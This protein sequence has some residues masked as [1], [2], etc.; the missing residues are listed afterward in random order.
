VVLE[1]DG[2]QKEGIERP[3]DERQGPPTAIAQSAT[4]PKRMIR[5]FARFRQHDQLFAGRNEARYNAGSC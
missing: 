5:R 1:R 4:H 3:P 2:N